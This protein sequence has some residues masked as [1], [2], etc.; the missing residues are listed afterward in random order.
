MKLPIGKDQFMTTYYI[1]FHINVVYYVI[2]AFYLYI[3]A[4]VC[5]QIPFPKCY[6]SIVPH[7]P[8]LFA[9]TTLTSSHFLIEFG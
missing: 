1:T 9:L 3:V 5:F 8:L 2:R 4:Y 6:T 7:S